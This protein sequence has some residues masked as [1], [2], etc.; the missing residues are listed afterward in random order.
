[1]SSSVNTHRGRSREKANDPLKSVQ[2]PPSGSPSS[3]PLFTHLSPG[4][5][6]AMS[7]AEIA[8]ELSLISGLSMNNVSTLVRRL[9]V[10]S[11]SMSLVL[12]RYTP[13][14]WLSRNFAQVIA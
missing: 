12:H 8:A 4:A 6:A 14:P 3:S 10:F 1:M 7:D 11:M 9:F 2:S 13:W 5:S